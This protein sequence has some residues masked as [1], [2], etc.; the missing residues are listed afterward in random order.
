M[1]DRTRV[2]A[3]FFLTSKIYF[4]FFSEGRL[5]EKAGVSKIPLAHYPD[6]CAGL[7]W[8]EPVLGARNALQVSSMGVGPP[9]AAF[10]GHQQ[11][12]GAEVEPV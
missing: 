11:G 1:S 4:L 3:C 6:G 9:A 12:A 5:S 2:Q 8:P 7:S 10:P